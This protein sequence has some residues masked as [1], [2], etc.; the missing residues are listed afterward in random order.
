MRPVINGSSYNSVNS[1]LGGV[2][3]TLDTVWQAVTGADKT[4]AQ[5]EIALATI[6]AKAK[7]DKANKELLIYGLITLAIIAVLYFIFKTK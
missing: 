2:L 3:G 1:S 7:A 6:E 4:K 5:S